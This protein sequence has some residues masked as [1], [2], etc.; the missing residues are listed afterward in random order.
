MLLMMCISLYTSR[1]VLEVLGIEDYG[2]YNVV[3]GVITTLSFFNGM[4]S[5]AS[6]RFITYALASKDNQKIKKVT[7]NCISVHLILAGI[8]V[9]ISETI[10]LWF[11]N[12]QLN[13]PANR[14]IAA[15]VI[16]QCVLLSFVMNIWSIPYNAMI[17]AHERMGTFAYISIL[18]VSLKLITVLLLVYIPFDKLILYAVMWMIVALLIRFIY[19]SYCI[20]NFEEG[21]SKP[22]I[23]KD[24][25]KNILSFSGYNLIEIFANM[26]SDQGL[27]IMLNI[28][29]GPIV[30][31]ARG[32]AV[33]VNNAIIGFTNNVTTAVQPQITKSC[34]SQ[35]F[36]RMTY[37]ISK[38]N[39]FSFFLLTII[40]VPIIF[41]A[42]YILTLWLKN[43]PEYSADFLRLLIIY[44]IIAMLTRTFYIG[45]CATGDIKRYQLTMGLIKLLILPICYGAL[46]IWLN[47][48]IVYFIII[49][50]EILSI[51]I[52]IFLIKD[53]IQL[54]VKKYVL[55]VITPCLIIS[56]P[57]FTLSWYINV[58]FKETFIQL[59]IYSIITIISNA[60]LIFLIGM[61]KG[62][63]KKVIY[64]ISHKIKHQNAL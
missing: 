1:I 10:G 24:L 33:Q 15:N 39:K 23:D 31:A 55:D 37:L 58:F 47:P 46:C 20:R 38:T 5:S 41:K 28:F 22:C 61:T 12:T 21:K 57:I 26:L 35:D 2:I 59:C 11:L 25:F 63:K 29:F 48:I 54:S 64:F 7:G 18:E 45:I 6:Q 8:V 49:I 42:E 3:G 43:P 30:N 62:E 51:G 34:A 52:R 27:N 9:L 60:I 56:I 4:L 44:N 17:V 36:A 50:F 32:I 53:K 40:T 19:S 13:I 14:M 16:Y